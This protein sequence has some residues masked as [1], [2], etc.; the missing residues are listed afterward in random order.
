MVLESPYPPLHIPDVSIWDLRFNEGGEAKQQIAQPEPVVDK[1]LLLSNEDGTQTYTAS[2]ARAA[3]LRFARALETTLSFGSGDTLAVLYGVALYLGGV[4]SPT[5]PGYGTEK[6]HHQLQDSGASVVV[7]QEPLLPVVLR[8]ATK[9]GIHH[10]RVIVLPSAKRSS[11]SS[12]PSLLPRARGSTLHFSEIVAEAEGRAKKATIRPGKDNAFLVYSSGTTGLPTGVQ[13]THRNIV[14]NILMADVVLSTGHKDV[15]LAFLPLFHI[16]GLTIQLHYACYKRAR[17][18]VMSQYTLPLLCKTIEA[19][20]VSIA[21]LVPPVASELAQSTLPSEAGID[22]SSIRFMTSAAAPLSPTIAYALYARHGIKLLE[23]YGLSETSPGA[24]RMSIE[25]YPAAIGTVGRLLPNQQAKLLGVDDS[26]R[27]I[28][29]ES[30]Q[31]GEI[32]IKGPNVF[33]G[34]HNNPNATRDAFTQDGY[35]RTG[36]IGVF[37][38]VPRVGSCLRI[39]DRL[40]EPIKYKGFQVAPAELEGVLLRHEGVADVCVVGVHDQYQALA[41]EVPRAYV[42]KAPGWREGE[43]ERVAA[44]DEIRR[45]SDKKLANHKR[46][47]GGIV[48]VDSLP[49]TPSGK[50]LRR[51]LRDT[52]LGGKAK[53]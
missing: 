42:V 44:A 50:L 45:W 35:F 31:S 19:H 21:Y 6:L 14:A 49:R 17:V 15:V 53:L 7:T 9:S 11:V 26:N 29:P 43:E 51:L 8:A 28:D 48:F 4:V 41:T 39:T 1:A 52:N 23:G 27:E 32:C 2:G 40:K 5:N 37:V 13:L 46:L 30:G 22:L 47:R 16:L 20:R 25:E 12:L 18:V 24:F 34:Y 38:K 33:R 36:D 10:G 3:A